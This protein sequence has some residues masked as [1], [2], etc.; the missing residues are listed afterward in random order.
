MQV[1]LPC[2]IGL[3][4]WVDHED[5]DPNAPWDPKVA[6]EDAIDTRRDLTNQILNKIPDIDWVDELPKW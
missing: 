1:K 2:A 5:S 4:D 6:F 3:D